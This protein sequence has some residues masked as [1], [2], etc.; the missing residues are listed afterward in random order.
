MARTMFEPGF[1]PASTTFNGGSQM[2]S[3]FTDAVKKYTSLVW[4]PTNPVASLNPAPGT[5][6]LTA[7]V[8]RAPEPTIMGMPQSTF[9]WGAAAVLGLG[10]VGAIVYSQKQKKAA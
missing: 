3:S 9:M 4:N 1:L 7:P 2:G 5:V 6:P 8:V 10:V